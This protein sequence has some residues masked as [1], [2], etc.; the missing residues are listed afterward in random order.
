MNACGDQAHL[1][2]VWDNTLHAG[3]LVVVGLW[4]QRVKDW[5]SVGAMS[6]HRVDLRFR[7]NLHNHLEIAAIHVRQTFDVLACQQLADGLLA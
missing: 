2:R 3:H 6:L 1:R 5:N 7:R 4:V